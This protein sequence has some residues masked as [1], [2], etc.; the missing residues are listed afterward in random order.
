MAVRKRDENELARFPPPNRIGSPDLIY[1]A[2]NT[3]TTDRELLIS[4]FNYQ[5][6]PGVNPGSWSESRTESPQSAGT[7]H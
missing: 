6:D 4:S 1:T 2:K 5:K 3:P 7:V